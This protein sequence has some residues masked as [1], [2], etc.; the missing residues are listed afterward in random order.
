MHVA[1]ENSEIVRTIIEL[2]KNLNMNVVA[3]GVETPDQFA[4]LRALNCDYGQGFLFSKPTPSK[5]AGELI[6]AVPYT[7]LPDS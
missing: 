1:A 3:E 4:D 5:R 6:G 2:A 7:K